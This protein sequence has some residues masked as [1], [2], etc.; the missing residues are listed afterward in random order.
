MKTKNLKPGILIG[1][2][3]VLSFATIFSVSA[4]DQ[5]KFHAEGRDQARERSII[6]T[7]DIDFRVDIWTERTVYYPGE[8][9][10]IFFHASRDCYVYIFDIDPRG[11]TRQIFPN[12]Y[13]QDNFIRAGYTY[14]I[15]DY[16]YRLEVTGPSGREYL[17]AIAVRDHY[18]F[19]RDFER[20]RRSDPF[21]R[22][23][24]GLKGFKQ[25]LESGARSQEW[26]E[27]QHKKNK[28]EL[29]EGK[30]GSLKA[31]NKPGSLEAEEKPGTL[32][33]ENKESEALEAGRRKKGVPAGAVPKE[34]VGVDIRIKKRV[35]PRPIRPHPP[36]RQY[37]ESYTS[38]NVRS[39]GYYDPYDD[40][41]PPVPTKRIRFSSIPDDALLYIDG[42]FYGKTTQR[43][44]LPFG[45]HRIR[46]RKRGYYD[47]VRTIYVDE[48]SEYRIMGNLRRRL[49]GYW[50]P[51][52]REWDGAHR[53][54]RDGKERFRDNAKESP[55]QAPYEHWGEEENQEQKLRDSDKTAPKN[56]SDQE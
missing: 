10:R 43:V 17:H 47:W 8:T 25:K 51:Y 50:Q 24:R 34:K 41:R 38:F 1:L 54:D 7:P 36:I 56:N 33:A 32:E 3:L 44:I 31:K 49:D 20:F 5:V 11:T 55:S 35:V 18:P 26:S 28:Q 6:V 22:H 9:I 37:A 29:L 13:D 16:G 12:Y 4:K 53:K 21:P 30:S 39:R 23:S 48:H 40:F 14:S 45:S 15:P 19:L 52:R 46:M 42:E 27:N 2:I